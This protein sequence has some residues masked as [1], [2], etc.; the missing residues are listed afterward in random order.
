MMAI[1]AYTLKPLA[2]GRG[3]RMKSLSTL[4]AGRMAAAS[5][6]GSGVL[7]LL[8]VLGG[9]WQSAYPA[10]AHGV[11][12]V[13]FTA[14]PR[15]VTLLLG[16]GLVLAGMH[17]YAWKRRAWALALTLV[18]AS[19][20]LHLLYAADLWEAICSLLLAGMLQV[21]RGQFQ[22]GA[23]RP[24]L[25]L[26]AFRAATAFSVAG[27]YGAVGFWLLEHGQFLHNFHWWDAA[28][29]A[30]RFLLL[31]GDESLVPR[32]V[33]AAW[34][35]DSLFW[36]SAA[37]FLYSGFVLFRPV[38]YRFRQDLR[39]A[40][41]AKHIADEYGRSAQDFF[42]HWPDKSYFFSESHKSFLS[43][44]VSRNYALV[45][46]DPVG[47]QDEWESTIDAFVRFCRRQG[48]RVGFHQV[49]PSCLS[50][51]EARGFR[52][53][54][55][56]EDAIVDLSRFSLTGSSMKEFR[57]TVNR[58]E[59]LGYRVQ[60]V[61]PPLSGPLV[62][63]LK[64]ISDTWLAMPGHRERQF[65]LGRFEASYVRTTPVYVAYD[66]QNTPVAFVNLAPS[67]QQG[68]STVDLMRRIPDS[69]N[70]LMDF[71][72]AKVFLDLKERGEQRFSLG[73]APLGD[74]RQHSSASIDERMVHWTI[75]KLPFLFRTDSLRRFKAKY[76]NDWLPRFAVFES[77]LDLPRLALA[78]RSVSELPQP[79]RRAA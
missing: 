26:A 49:G 66:A 23:G 56:G 67:Y 41:L 76:A 16:F 52:W 17:L 27:L 13:D 1:R 40:S 5:I 20:C 45:F 62:G 19:A 25:A 79:L 8:S 42:K 54:R 69:V 15:S 34:F 68:L 78:L 12:P 33:Y 53:M 72:F 77:R 44:R 46:G 63:D 57:N 30:I 58:L 48:W 32:T 55:V 65:T 71:L 70:G 73:M 50:M 35:L 59:R 60:R 28:L 43:Y 10:W 22:I 11:F 64:R 18:S 9:G 75:R 7:N 38:S 4:A 36:M 29:Q 14:L 3:A 31:F 51:Y 37:S 2:A 47:P 24:Q 21:S 39:G 74:G 6:T 61:D